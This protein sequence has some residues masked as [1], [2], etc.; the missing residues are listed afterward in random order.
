MHGVVLQ[1]LTIPSR[2]RN[3]L[4]VVFVYARSRCRATTR[5]GQDICINDLYEVVNMARQNKVITAINEMLDEHSY[6]TA[7]QIQVGLG[8][9]SQGAV[10]NALNRYISQGKLQ[11]VDV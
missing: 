9:K 2:D 4:W 3:T 7:K 5:K 11:R 1:E 10:A 8:Y 6:L